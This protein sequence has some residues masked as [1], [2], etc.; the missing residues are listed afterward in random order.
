MIPRLL[1]K[2]NGHPGER[3]HGHDQLARLHQV[4]SLFSDR[5]IRSRRSAPIRPELM[6][7]GKSR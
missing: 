6:E 1:R 5:I 4:D 2:V 3:H 7:G